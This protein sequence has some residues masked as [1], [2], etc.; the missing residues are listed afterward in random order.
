MIISTFSAPR[1]RWRVRELAALDGR[2]AHQIQQVDY[3]QAKRELTGETLFER[4]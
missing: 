2:E 4:Q 3:E 1:V